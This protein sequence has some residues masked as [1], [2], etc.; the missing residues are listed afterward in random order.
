MTPRR[1]IVLLMTGLVLGLL[2][3]LVSVPGTV[4]AGEASLLPQPVKP[5]NATKCVRPV[6]DM[7]RNHMLYLKH[8]RV[9]TLRQGIRGNPF[10]LKKCVS[11]HA[12]PDKA[13]GGARTIRPFCGACHKYAAVKPDCFSC[14]S[15]KVEDRKAADMP[16]DDQHLTARMDAFLKERSPV[17]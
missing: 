4:L 8:Q 13:A 10:S 6:E 12:V 9:E 11:C 2:G 14:H 1:Q 5:E 7:R 15:G 16:R 3:V 17:K